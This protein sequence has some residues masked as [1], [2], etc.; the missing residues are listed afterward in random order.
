MSKWSDWRPFPDPR[1]GSYLSAPFGIGVY[2]LRNRGTGELVLYGKSKNV[3]RRM[4]SILPPPLGAGT[5]NNL[6]KREY[7]L[8]H[9]AEIDYRTMACADEA[10]AL[11]AEANLRSS[12]KYRFPT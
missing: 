11:A 1:S 2:E 6:A 10:A 4:S 12:N 9:L 3:A 7:V 8:K 5:R